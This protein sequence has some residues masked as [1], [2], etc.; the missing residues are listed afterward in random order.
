MLYELLAGKLPYE[1]HGIAIHEVATVVREKAPTPL[2]SLRPDLRGDLQTIV[3]CA[4]MKDRDKRY[5]SAHELREDLRRFLA[6]SAI[7]AN[8][9]TLGYQ[10]QILARRNKAA[11]SRGS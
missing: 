11:I 6:G 4:L 10:L 1:L 3:S 9:P 8:P 5:Q 2:R 7:N